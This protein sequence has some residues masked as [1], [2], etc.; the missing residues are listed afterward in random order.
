MKKSASLNRV[1]QVIIFSIVSVTL[2]SCGSSTR[3]INSWSD[4]EMTDNPNEWEKVLVIVQSPNE[5]MRRVAEDRVAS[6]NPKIIVS[7]TILSESVV[8]DKERSRELIE[9]ADIDAIMTFKL[10]DEETQL[11]YTPGTYNYYD[12]RMGYWGY[13]DYYWGNYYN[14]GYYTTDMVYSVETQVFSMKDNKLVYAAV[15]ETTNPDRIDDA[16][17][18]VTKAT[19]H[20]MVRDGFI[21]H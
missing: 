15:S 3:I 2:M 10:I 18:E 6:L 9:S 4:P 1:I 11:N 13:H 16:I 5:G 8:Q 7:Y 21:T 20:Q 12:Y 17:E 19:F 14:S